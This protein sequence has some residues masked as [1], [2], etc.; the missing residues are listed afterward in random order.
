VQAGLF[1]DVA[2]RQAGRLFEALTAGFADP[3]MD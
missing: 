2:H 1:G 3:S